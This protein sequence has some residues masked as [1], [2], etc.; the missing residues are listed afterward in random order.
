MIE[1]ICNPEKVFCLLGQNARSAVTSLSN[2]D[3]VD[4]FNSSS[5]FIGSYIKA[6]STSGFSYL[7]AEE[8]DIS[9]CTKYRYYTLLYSRDICA[10]IFQS[11]KTSPGLPTPSG[12]T[13]NFTNTSVSNCPPGS[14]GWVETLFRDN[15][16]P[17]F[18]AIQYK[19]LKITSFS[20]PNRPVCYAMIC[21][22]DELYTPGLNGAVE[23]S[24]SGTA[25]ADG[26]DGA[27]ETGNSDN[28]TLERGATWKML[29]TGV[30]QKIVNAQMVRCYP[31]PANKQLT[32]ATPGLKEKIICTIELTDVTGK[33][34]YTQTQ[35]FDNTT[36]IMIDVSSFARGVYIL[37]FTGKSIN[38]YTQKITVQ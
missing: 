7:F 8:D 10:D 27:D 34:I 16:S 29:P 25:G 30:Q 9:T 37:K 28:V 5:G 20:A 23:T 13:I 15:Q 3:D 33:T 11:M 32:I 6:S 38:T 35:L 24:G 19:E 22:P 31:N 1:E 14:G 2:S 26:T 21:P 36:K 12:A 4:F 18:D 17:A